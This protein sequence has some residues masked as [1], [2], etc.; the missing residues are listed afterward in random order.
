[1]TRALLVVDAGDSMFGLDASMVREILPMRG[2]TRLPGAPA[3]VRGLLNVRGT[4]VTVVDLAAQAGR[5]IVS[6]PDASVVILVAAGRTL[7]AVVDDVKE[8]HQ[9]D[10]EQ[11]LTPPANDANALIRALGH[12]ESRVVLE[13]DVLELVR[14]TLA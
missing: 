5:G 1:M 3:P 2:V 9:F 13:V 7:G 12:F 6:A 8:I 10:V 11:L 14:Q 4:L